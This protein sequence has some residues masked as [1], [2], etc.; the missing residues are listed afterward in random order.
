MF[1]VPWL[2][3]VNSESTASQNHSNKQSQYRPD[4]STQR[5]LS[6]FDYIIVTSMKYVPHFFGL[7]SGA[8]LRKMPTS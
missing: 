4:L 2:L 6:V 8:C 5:S 3:R 1:D 7:T